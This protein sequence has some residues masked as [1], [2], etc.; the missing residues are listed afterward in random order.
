ME[1]MLA[2]EGG[3]FLSMQHVQVARGEQVVLHDVSLEIPLGAHVAILGPNGCGK[4]TLI[5]TIT[6]ECY[7]MVVPGMRCTLLGRERWD[8]SQMRAHLGV[9][10][11]DLPGERTPVTEGRTAVL[12]GFFAA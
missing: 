1:A 11:A 12:A 10:A 3:S 7:P 6:R 4:S 2:G 8:V 9:V 5:K